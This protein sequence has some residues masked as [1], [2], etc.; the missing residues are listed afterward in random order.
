MVKCDMVI[1]DD[2][3]SPEKKTYDFIT[4]IDVNEDNFIELIIYSNSLSSLYWMK[5]SEPFIT[6]FGWNAKFWIYLIIFIYTASSIVGIYEFYKL[7]RLN[8]K[9]AQEKALLKEEQSGNASSY[10]DNQIEMKV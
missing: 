9:F 2:K 5:Q 10:S 1:E 6:S 3:L 7:K 4:E 8:D